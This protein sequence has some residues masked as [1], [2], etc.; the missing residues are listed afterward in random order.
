MPKDVK[1]TTNNEES[2]ISPDTYIVNL[3]ELETVEEALINVNYS[4]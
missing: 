2:A 4:V 3:T 1:N